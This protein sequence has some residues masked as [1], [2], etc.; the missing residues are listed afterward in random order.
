MDKTAAIVLIA[1]V[2]V[3]VCA[4]LVF[5]SCVWFGNDSKVA[6]NVS[7]WTFLAGYFVFV[8]T[9]SEL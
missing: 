1:S 3:W 9:L 6:L 8:T 5:A 2:I 4:A 7:I